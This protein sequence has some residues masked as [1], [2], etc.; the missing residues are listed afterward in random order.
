MLING[1][2]TE[3]RDNDSVPAL[4]SDVL[5]HSVPLSDIAR[6][7]GEILNEHGV[8]LKGCHYDSTCPLF[9]LGLSPLLSQEEADALLLRICNLQ[10][11]VSS[12]LRGVLNTTFV[13]NSYGLDVDLEAYLCSPTQTDSVSQLKWNISATEVV[14]GSPVHTVDS[15]FDDYKNSVLFNFH[16]LFEPTAPLQEPD[17]GNIARKLSRTQFKLA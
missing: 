10:Q 8:T 11:G 3:I 16:N 7:I 17:S 2:E 15:H 1:K 6:G 9:I 4:Y 13:P 12:A 14:S 5:D